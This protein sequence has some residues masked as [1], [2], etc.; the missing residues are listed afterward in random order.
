MPQ[1]I[2]YETQNSECTL[3]KIDELVFHYGST[4]HFPKGYIIFSQ[5]NPVRKFYWLRQ[6]LVK[7]HKFE[8]TQGNSIL[9]INGDQSF[10][11]LPDAW[12]GDQHHFSA[13]TLTQVEITEIDTQVFRSLLQEQPDVAQKIIS[14]LAG[15]ALY[16]YERLNTRHHK[17]LPGRV[18][19]TLLFFYDFFGQEPLFAFPLSRTE[20]AQF[21]GTTRE[22]LIR[23]LA[24]FKN[25]KIINLN[26]R[27]VE[28]I[29]LEIICTLSRLG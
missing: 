25:D 19:D 18:A 21:T 11:G 3:N 20:L 8:G 4:S 9:K 17:Q 6:G 12:S 7:L 23:T 29:S 22:S 10:P 16:Y 24:E 14:L 13:T 28:I 15:E 1:K 26:D 5:G 27:Q 2:N